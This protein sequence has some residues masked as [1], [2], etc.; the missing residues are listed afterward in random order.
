MTALRD[1][2]LL[3]AVGVGA[4]LAYHW[5]REVSMECH[6]VEHVVWVQP[7]VEH[8][9]MPERAVVTVCREAR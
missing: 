7:T 9:A 6:T 1:L 2:L 8:R 3:S 4:Y 5:P